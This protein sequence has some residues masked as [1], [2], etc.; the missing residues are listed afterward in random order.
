M[1]RHPP[2]KNTSEAVCSSD[3]EPLLCPVCVL[4]WYLHRTQ[5]LSRPRHHFHS[6]RDPTLPLSKTAI[7]YFLQQLIRAAY[8]DFPGYLGLTLQIRAHDVQILATSLLWFTNKAVADVMAVA[9]WQTQSV[10]ATH[11]LKA[12]HKVQDGIFSPGP[13]VAADSVIS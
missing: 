4:R 9:Y 7:S 2:I 12:V 1:L 6:V 3:N 5:S 11:Y 13:I 8:E 10:F